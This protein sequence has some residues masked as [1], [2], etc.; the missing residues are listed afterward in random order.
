MFLL[1]LT[2]TLHHFHKKRTTLWCR[3]YISY[4]DIYSMCKC[5]EGIVGYH[6]HVL[7]LLCHNVPYDGQDGGFKGN[8]H[9]QIH[10]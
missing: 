4:K 6:D 8:H 3:D 9:S 10:P 5:P 7:L 2:T 1:D